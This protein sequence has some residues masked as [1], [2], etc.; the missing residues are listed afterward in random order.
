MNKAVCTVG[1]GGL[2]IACLFISGTALA[3]VDHFF[4]GDWLR[5]TPGWFVLLISPLSL[6]GIWRWWSIFY[7]ECRSFWSHKD[8]FANGGN[9]SQ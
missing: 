8:D 4:L 1:A 2:T 6:I 7:G 9:R 3:I 5:Q